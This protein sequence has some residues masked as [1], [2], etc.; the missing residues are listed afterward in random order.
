MKT[1]TKVKNLIVQVY[2]KSQGY[3]DNGLFEILLAKD[4][5]G[6]TYSISLQEGWFNYGRYNVGDIFLIKSASMYSPSPNLNFL[7]YVRIK[8]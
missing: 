4:E 3:D 2:D 5:Q 6:K 8:H 1:T 7:Y